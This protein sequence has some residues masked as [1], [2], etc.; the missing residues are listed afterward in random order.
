MK[1]YGY[2]R[3][4][5]DE[6][7]ITTQ[8]TA[9]KNYHYHQLF[10]ESLQIDDA[11]SQELERLL[12]LVQPGDKIL[13]YDL[14]VFGKNLAGLSEILS[15]LHQQEVSLF[16][17]KDKID[18]NDPQIVSLCQNILYLASIEKSVMRENTLRGLNLARKKGKVGS[19]PTLPPKLIEHILYLYHQKGYSLKRISEECEISI[20][21]VHKYI[22][23]SKVKA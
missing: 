5:T 12:E 20:G 18:T 8:M 17:V 15:Y 10:I 2:A 16:L 9:L 4:T 7:F 6:T 21:S 19:R 13:V 14:T 1:V 22:R 3:I 23:K 11:T